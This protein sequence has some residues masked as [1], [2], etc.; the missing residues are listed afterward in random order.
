MIF[1]LATCFPVPSVLRV[2]FSNVSSE[3]ICVGSNLGVIFL[4]ISTSIFS[5]FSSSVFC[6][7]KFSNF[8]MISSVL[9][10]FFLIVLTF[11]FLGFTIGVSTCTASGTLSS[12]V[13]VT[14]VSGSRSSS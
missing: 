8:S 6:T 5:Y 3:E 9:S 2:S 10:P 13:M 14:V 12:S 1:L 11:F 4:G 7:S